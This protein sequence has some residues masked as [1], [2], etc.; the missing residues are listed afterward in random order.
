LQSL[1]LPPYSDSSD[2]R[3]IEEVDKELTSSKT[4]MR[5]RRRPN[6]DK[7][8]YLVDEEKDLGTQDTIN[9]MYDRGV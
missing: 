8:E 2:G 6:E 7:Q 3:S 9:E 4:H 1:G 5:V